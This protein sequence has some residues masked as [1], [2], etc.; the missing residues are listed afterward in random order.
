MD[1]IDLAGRAEPAQEREAIPR[2]EEL[3]PPGAVTVGR[4][5]DEVVPLGE[6]RGEDGVDE[7]GDA[8]VRGRVRPDDRHAQA[9]GRGHTLGVAERGLS[10][11]Y[12]QARR[13]SRATL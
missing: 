13:S 3:R 7:T 11:P 12:R 4:D 6:A 5:R 1:E 2:L 10:F 9:P 8:S